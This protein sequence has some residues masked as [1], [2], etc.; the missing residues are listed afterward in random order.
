MNLYHLSSLSRA[1][2]DQWVLIARGTRRAS[3]PSFRDLT[4]KS[5][6][7]KGGRPGVL[8]TSRGIQSVAALVQRGRVSQCA[9]SNMNN[10]YTCLYQNFEL[11][12]MGSI[13]FGGDR[14]ERDSVRKLHVATENNDK[15]LQDINSME[16]I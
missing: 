2:V 14:R 8:L 13:A 10:T 3:N 1:K 6:Q 16:A 12:S 9:E 11:Y 15:D 4:K 7:R 5:D